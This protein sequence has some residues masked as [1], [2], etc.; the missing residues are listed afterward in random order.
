MTFYLN[1]ILQISISFI[2]SAA[3]SIIF[4]SP[5]EHIIPAGLTGGFGWLIYLILTQNGLSV[6]TASFFATVGLTA[7]SRIFSFLRKAP[8]TIFLIT[9]IFPLVPGIGIYLTG[10][11]LFMGDKNATLSNGVQ[12]IEIAI[13]MALGVGLV[14]SLPQMLF[15]FK[16]LKKTPKEKGNL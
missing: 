15:S 9:G 2:A 11:N 7:L 8:V 10:Y 16:R 4:H 13:A 6:I 5:K 14:L 12:T 1:L 3:F